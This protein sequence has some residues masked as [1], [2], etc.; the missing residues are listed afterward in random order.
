MPDKMQRRRAVLE[1]T[2]LSTSTIYEMMARGDFPRPLRLGKR[3][4]G[5]RESDLAK[6]LESREQAV[7]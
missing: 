7:S 2:G 3:A 4:V 6:W 5:W 1:L